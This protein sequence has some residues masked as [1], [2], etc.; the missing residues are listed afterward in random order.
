MRKDQEIL[1]EF[2]DKEEDEDKKGY[3][4]QLFG[5]NKKKN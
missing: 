2:I 4:V 1:I 5:N 3:I